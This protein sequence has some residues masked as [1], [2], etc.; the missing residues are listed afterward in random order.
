[1]KSNFYR[2]AVTMVSL[3]CFTTLVAQ[4]SDQDEDTTVL[5]EVTVVGSQIRGA[6]I[7]GALPVS[8][9]DF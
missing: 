6:K 5:E 4:E 7:T 2:V 9:F 3:F 1:M 8:I